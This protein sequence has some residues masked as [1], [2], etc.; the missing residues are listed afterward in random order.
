MDPLSELFAAWRIRYVVAAAK[1]AAEFFVLRCN[2][3]GS[4]NPPL[5]NLCLYMEHIASSWV[6]V[7]RL[8]WNDNCKG[9]AFTLLRGDF[10]LA[11]VQA[12]YTLRPV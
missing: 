1:P 8:E 6:L 10:K 5:K 3:G 7:R 12:Y 9:R 11:A 4:Q 2:S